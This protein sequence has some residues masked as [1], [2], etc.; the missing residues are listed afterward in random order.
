MLPDKT[1]GELNR[2]KPSSKII[3]WIIPWIPVF[4]QFVEKTY[5]EPAVHVPKI[6]HSTG[7]I[8][9]VCSEI[10]DHREIE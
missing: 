5:R 8:I 4:P 10:W 7:G 1:F 2:D 3:W 9:Q 6:I